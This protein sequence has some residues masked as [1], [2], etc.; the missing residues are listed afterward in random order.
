MS[1]WWRRSANDV[2]T[3]SW[4]TASLV[5]AWVPLLIVALGSGAV[6]VGGQGAGAPLYQWAAV[7]LATLSTL[8]IHIAARPRRRR[9]GTPVAVLVSVLASSAVLLSGWGIGRASQNGDDSLIPELWWAPV[10]VSLVV[11]SLSP[12]VPGRVFL[13]AG[14]MV[15]G[16]S[17]LAAAFATEPLA[18]VSPGAEIVIAASSPLFALI[19]GTFLTQSLIEQVQ[20]WRSGLIESIAAPPARE[21]AVSIIDRATHG[22]LT[23][24]ALPFLRAI[25]DGAPVDDATRKH[26]SEL[27]A[28]LRTALIDRDGSGWLSGIIAR[29]PVHVTDPQR[30]AERVSLD[31]R[32]AIIALIDG[33]FSDPAAGVY[34]AR[35]ELAPGDDETVGVALT[36]D[37]TL[38]EGRRTSA[39]APY[40]LSAKSVVRDISWTNGRSVVV[41]FGVDGEQ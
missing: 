38:P 41:R 24:E 16:A 8:A 27:A 12:F 9:F 37:L 21:K 20:G 30:L 39:L 36:L 13:P 35:L 25:G 32:A 26:A 11:M 10:A 33:V 14:A 17:V 4:L 1:V 23:G 40:Y 3:L 34:A 19:G 29:R 18:A 7:L 15:A 28:R 2:D 22:A 5:T 6:L 31:Q